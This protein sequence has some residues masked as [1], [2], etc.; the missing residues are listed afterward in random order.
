[1]KLALHRS[2]IFWSG[3]L[4]IAFIV[5]AWRDSVDRAPAAAF[6]DTILVT[7]PDGIGI[8]HMH[9]RN[10]PFE[11]TYRGHSYSHPEWAACQPAFFIRG[12][13]Q[14]LNTREEWESHVKQLQA[15]T[16]AREFFRPPMRVESSRSWLLFIP[17]WM[18]LLVFVL[19][20]AALLLWRVRRWKRMTNDE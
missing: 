5:W 3:L 12:G 8:C 17:H 20:W 18:I 6:H 16:N 13:G 11:A 19:A 7:V 4:V 2:V 14:Q 10:A 1:M 9:D 15:A